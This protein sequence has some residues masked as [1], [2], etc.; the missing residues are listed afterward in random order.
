M[1]PS[2]AIYLHL[3]FVG[4]ETRVFRD[5]LWAVFS[6][7]GVV[8]DLLHVSDHRLARLRGIAPFDCLENQPVMD[9]ASGWTSGNEEDSESLFAENCHNRVEQRENQWIT[10]GLGQ[11]KVKIEV[12]LDVRIGV[13]HAAIHHVDGLAHHGQ[14]LF[15]DPRGRKGGEL[16]FEDLA[17]FSDIPVILWVGAVHQPVERMPGGLGLACGHEGAP[18]GVG[19]DQPLF[20]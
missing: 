10:G 16:G 1:N 7:H 18:A 6:L 11:R 17:Q 12:R 5:L 13:L 2:F 3:S 20:A 4:Y 9:L 15:F 8:A 14:L 19:F